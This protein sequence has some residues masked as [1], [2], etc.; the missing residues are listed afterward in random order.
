LNKD[1]LGEEGGLN[2]YVNT[3]NNLISSFDPI[4]LTS[5]S[6]GIKS[7]INAFRIT[8]GTIGS[9][10]DLDLLRDKGTSLVKNNTNS[11]QFLLTISGMLNSQADNENFPK[12]VQQRFPKT[13]GTIKDFG[14]ANN[15]TALITD[16]I[17][18]VFLE[19]GAI[20]SPSQTAAKYIEEA[21]ENAKK[22]CCKCIDIYIIS[23]SQGGAVLNQALPLLSQEIKKTLRII[24]IGP[25]QFIR[26]GGQYGY[27]EN[28]DSQADPVPELSPRNWFFP[29]NEPTKQEVPGHPRDLYLDYLKSKGLP[30]GFYRSP[31]TGCTP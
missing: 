19:S 12:D 3:F 16:F 8:M 13:L 30:S 25:E 24:N 21:Y 17:Q 10:I 22:N 2:L 28:I 27:V 7:V 26:D 18:I 15:P 20:G 4:G 9:A 1:P 14:H 31:N 11:C 6:E 23:H 5:I 29:E